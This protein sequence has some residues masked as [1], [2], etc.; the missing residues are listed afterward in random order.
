ML[1]GVQASK[2][3]S[4]V[5]YPLGYNPSLDGLRAFS[6]TAVLLFHAHVPGFGWGFIGVD[7][8]FVIS[9][10]LI[11][12]ALLAEESRKGRISLVGFYWRRALRLLP[13]LAV[14]CIVFLMLSIFVKPGI[15]LALKEVLIVALYAGNWVMAFKFGWMHY[16]G[17][18]WSLAIEE[19]FY[20]LWP[21][22][23]VVLL[24]LA[25]HRASAIFA[26]IVV[27]IVLVAAWRAFLSSRSVGV[28]RL[29]FGTDTRIDTLLIGSA[30]AIVFSARWAKEAIATA[31]R[32]LW[33]PSLVV[34]TT[35][36]AVAMF[37]RRSMFLG[38]TLVAL[39]AAVFVAGCKTDGLFSRILGTRP[40]V[41]VGQR[42][43]GIYLWHNFILVFGISTFALSE[44]VAGA[45]SIVGA[46]LCAAASYR[47]ME[48]PFL[49]RK[50]SA[51]PGGVREALQPA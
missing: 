39:C 13:A 3:R 48:R 24:K 31:T 17:H 22:F 26:V 9:G 2:T 37:E 38:Y 33:L 4:G 25:K 34:V 27:L 42:S 32:W 15:Y 30:L 18:T 19:Q 35:L 40:L 51:T 11:T 6:V 7:I 29:Y 46:I 16:L 49:R 20:F 28:D 43:Y 5:F 1:L 8:F 41:W 21:V 50:Y 12:S 47:W 36:P 10:F 45:I 44:P 23:L 14:L